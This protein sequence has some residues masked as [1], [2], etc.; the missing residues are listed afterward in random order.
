MK[1]CVHDMCYIV[2]YS[3]LYLYPFYSI[4]HTVAVKTL[5]TSPRQDFLSLS[6]LHCADLGGITVT[7]QTSAKITAEVAPETVHAAAKS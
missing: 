3:Y 2:S 5:R 4:K 7:K 1:I 6:V